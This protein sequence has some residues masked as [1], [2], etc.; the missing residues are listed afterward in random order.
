[1]AG[2]TSDVK[3][4]LLQL[5]IYSINYGNEGGSS[6][7]SIADHYIIRKLMAFRYSSLMGNPNT[8]T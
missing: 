8:F 6:S 4:K 2:K 3:V 1:M 5:T 7:V